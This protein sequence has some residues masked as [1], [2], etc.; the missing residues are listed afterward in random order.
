MH[1]PPH[2]LKLITA[3]KGLP[4][5]GEKTAERFAFQIL[6]WP[7][8][9]LQTLASTLSAVP[10][11]L[12]HCSVCGCL[13]GNTP[14]GLCD[15]SQ[16]DPTQL[17][18][19]ASDKDVFVLDGTGT[20]RGIY[21]VLGGLLSPIDGKGTE[22]LRLEQLRRRI[23]ELGVKEV[24]LAL[25]STLDGDATALFLKRELESLD[26]T[27]SRL[28]FGLPLGSSFDYVDAGTLSRALSGRSRA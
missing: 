8:E 25:D 1:L 16:R 5:V 26:V 18:I 2:L 4:G 13:I 6:K 19:V 3:L 11:E 14:C 28:A 24:I 27:L 22:G 10:D 21:H 23:A 20:F 7:K 15:L 17:A 9:R 12:R